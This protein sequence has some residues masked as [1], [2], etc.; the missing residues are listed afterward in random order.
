MLHLEQELARLKELLLTMAS[1]AE[2][3]VKQ[4]IEA[5]V[6]RDYDLALRVRANDEVIDRFEVEVD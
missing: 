5:V 6:S 1:H 4:A 2:T 3:A